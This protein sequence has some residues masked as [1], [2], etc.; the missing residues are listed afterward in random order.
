MIDHSFVD[1]ACEFCGHVDSSTVDFSGRYYIA[2]IRSGIDEKTYRY[3]CGILTE[4]T[5][6]RY[7][8]VDSG[9]EDIPSGVFAS[10]AD[11]MLTF[12]ITKCDDGSYVIYVEGVDGDV[13][14]LGWDSVKADNNGILVAEAEALHLAITVNNNGLYNLTFVDGE[15]NTRYLALNNTVDYA[16]AAWYKSG[17]QIQNLALIPIVEEAVIAGAQLNIGTDL[18]MKYHVALA[19]G[20]DISDYFMRFTI[21]G[22]SFDV[23]NYTVVNGKYVFAF[24]GIVPQCMGDNILAEVL[25]IDSETVVAVKDNYS[26]KAYADRMLD[27]YG[28]NAELAQLLRDLLKYGAEAQ[29][30]RGHNTDNLVSTGAPGYSNTTPTEADMN[31][32]LTTADG[33]TTDNVSFTAAGVRFDYVNNIY[34]KIKTDDVENV[35]VV[36]NGLT[37]LELL[38]TGTAGVYVAYSGGI[39][40]L[41]FA[42][43]V[44]FTVYYNGEL[45]QT[46]TYT[47]NSY[48][49]DKYEDANIGNLVTAL[50][51]YG[52]SAVAYADAN[53]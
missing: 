43:V 7:S 14:Y 2:G 40:A 8:L 47:V 53:K 48:A 50:Y 25:L 44:T 9:S 5:T 33:K 29:K 46:L 10:Q 31:R 3:I 11:G 38:E 6:K 22:E 42:E 45:I 20:T 18:T 23:Y 49:C 36:V 27:K 52:K 51:N 16:Y 37:E 30:Y 15:G 19:E 28:D 26:I 12:V 32:S 17:N 34:V 39:S 13:K 41:D 35:K 21:N 1:G 24:S 4:S